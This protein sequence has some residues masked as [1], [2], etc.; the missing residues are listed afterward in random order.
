MGLGPSNPF[1]FVTL[2]HSKTVM[3]LVIFRWLCLRG[4]YSISRILVTYLSLY[5]QHVSIGKF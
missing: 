3:H 1:S 4:F 2:V 5:F